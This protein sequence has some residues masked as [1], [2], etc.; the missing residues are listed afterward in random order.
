MTA[1]TVATSTFRQRGRI[2]AA[3]K[4]AGLAKAFVTDEHAPALAKAG[5]APEYGTPMLTFLRGI[6]STAAARLLTAL[7]DIKEPAR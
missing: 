7:R 4:E 3:L 1:T 2:C 6:S 5:L